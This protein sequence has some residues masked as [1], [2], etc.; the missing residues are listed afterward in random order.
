ME[1]GTSP[2]PL[3]LSSNPL[4]ISWQVIVNTEPA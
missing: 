2:V 4:F 3:I 1:I